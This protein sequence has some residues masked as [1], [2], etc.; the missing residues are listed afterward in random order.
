MLPRLTLIHAHSLLQLR[1]LAPSSQEI[2]AVL[3]SAAAD[4]AARHEQLSFESHHPDAVV[5]FLVDSRR[6]V[7]PV[8]DHDAPEKGSRHRAIPVIT[9]H[10]TVRQA[11]HP[12]LLQYFGILEF[13]RFSKIV[14]RKEGCPSRFLSLEQLDHASGCLRVFRH[15]VLDISTQCDFDSGLIFFVRLEKIRDNADHALL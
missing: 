5:V 9:A 12:G 8:H 11:D 10:K 13:L 1:H 14:Q 4:R 2:T 3:E 7:E 6:V 15:D